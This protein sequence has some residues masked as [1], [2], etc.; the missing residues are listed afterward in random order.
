MAI[1]MH[2]YQ[3]T[4]HN[5]RQGVENARKLKQQDRQFKIAQ[6][7]KQEEADAN[8]AQFQQS[9]D[10]SKKTQEDNAAYNRGILALRK[11][12][13]DTDKYTFEQNKK[14]HTAMIGINKDLAVHLKEKGKKE[15]DYKNVYEDQPWYEQLYRDTMSW[16]PRV[17]TREEAAKRQSGY[18]KLKPPD[19]IGEYGDI[20]PQYAFEKT[21]DFFPSEFGT[22]AEIDLS[23]ENSPLKQASQNSGLNTS[24]SFDPM[25]NIWDSEKPTYQNVMNLITPFNSSY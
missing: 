24:A 16:D 25:S 4:W 21:K 8:K 2:Q 6:Q 3:P 14:T 10:L 5:F 23:M 13:D 22:S 19:L 20:L 9:H 15:T 11:D 12:Q 1:S 7:L 18:D 17:E